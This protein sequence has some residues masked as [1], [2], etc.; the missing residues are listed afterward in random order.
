MPASQLNNTPR[1][2]TFALLAVGAAVVAVVVSGLAALG[3]QVRWR[4]RA[5]H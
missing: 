4:R 2:R 1:S 3:S 5:P